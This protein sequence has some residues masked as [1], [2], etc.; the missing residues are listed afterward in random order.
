M[1]MLGH[2]QPHALVTV[3]AIQDEDDLFDRTGA[4]LAGKGRQFHLEEWD[5]D[6]RGQMKDGAPR[7]GMDKPH[8]VAPLEVVLDWC[9]WALPVETPDLVQDRLQSDAMLVRA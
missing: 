9:E 4:D 7:G 2:A 5:A 8:E 1:H 6:R 3:G